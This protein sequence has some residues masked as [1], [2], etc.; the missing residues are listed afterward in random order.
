[1]KLTRR[2]KNNPIGNKSLGELSYD[3]I[4]GHL[5]YLEICKVLEDIRHY[6]AN[7]IH[8]ISLISDM[9]PLES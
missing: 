7:A 8:F 9:N 2:L 4:M 6:M 3:D 5:A 1:M